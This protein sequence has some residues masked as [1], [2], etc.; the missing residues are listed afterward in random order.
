MVALV[1]PIYSFSA[2]GMTNDSLLCDRTI[3]ELEERVDEIDVRLASLSHFTLRGGV[4]AIGYRSLYSA[5]AK[6]PKSIG[7]SWDTPKKIDE[8]ILVPVIG[9]AHVN[10][11]EAEGFPICF[12]IYC[13]T[14]DPGNEKLIATYTEDDALLP[15][16][17]PLVI[18]FGGVEASW[19]RIDV[20]KLA[21]D[22]FGSRHI[23]QLAETMVFNGTKNVALHGHVTTTD[24]R[25]SGRAWRSE[26]LVD[27][28]VPYL[29]DSPS[30]EPS[31]SV[32]SQIG[33]G[34]PAMLTIDLEEEHSIDRIHLHTAQLTDN[35]PYM[36]DSR[37]GV[38]E[39]LRIEGAHQSDFSDSTILLDFWQSSAF[40]TAPIIVRNIPPQT[41]RY[42]RLIASTPYSFPTKKKER[43]RFG[44][45]EIELFSGSENVALGKPFS[46]NFTLGYFAKTTTPL[47]DGRNL[48]GNILPI[49]GWLDELALRQKLEKERPLVTKE[50]NHRYTRQKK[51]LTW[52]IRLA[53]VLGISIIFG[54][55]FDWALRQRAIYRTRERIAAD[56]HDELGANLHAIGLLGNLARIL[57]DS[58][59]EQSDIL[60]R[61]QE[62][63]KRTGLAARYC[64][65]TLNAKELYEDLVEDMRRTTERLVADLDHE[66]LFNDEELLHRLKLRR[67]IDLF[68][69]Y[70]ECLAN[71][72]RHSGA[73]RVSV[74]VEM[75]PKQLAVT[76]SDN[77]RGTGDIVPRS[78]RRRA[79]LLGATVTATTPADGG[80]CIQLTRSIKKRDLMKKES[81]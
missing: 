43:S 72:I 51:Q 59:D 37:F 31:P 64:T 38:P 28:F 74:R 54:V 10:H 46:A 77:G 1:I 41:C 45:A 16:T 25:R 50:L 13:G 42:V 24:D 3:P 2:I 62:M 70:K 63:A 34:D 73:T 80:T 36:F 15:R 60:I 68:L 23:L 8:I 58:P 44:F 75:T 81:I 47:T 30:G 17:A 32:I 79:R 4:G 21:P 27:G 78:L 29:M 55:F 9:R 39:H 76:V 7:V 61:L 65:N 67:R 40:D 18:P 11:Y 35:L 48:Y 49:R 33:T 66:I 52:L 71:I 22:P 14:S 56:I 57:K 6:K 53:G 69:F 19:I 20:S 12:S 5:N 26:N